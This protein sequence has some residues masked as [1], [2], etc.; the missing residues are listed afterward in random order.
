MGRQNGGLERAEKD[1]ETVKR[2]LFA[3]GVDGKDYQESKD[4]HGS[5][6]PG[7]IFRRFMIATG[8]CLPNGLSYE[9]RFFRNEKDAT[10]RAPIA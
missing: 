9:S 5:R 3:A 6:A 8:Q 1:Q 10:P 7:G 2:C 4:S